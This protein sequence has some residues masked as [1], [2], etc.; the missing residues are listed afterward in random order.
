MSLDTLSC[1]K[2]ICCGWVSQVDNQL[3]E[4]QK[5][6]GISTNERTFTMNN[7]STLGSNVKRGIVRFCERISEG[8]RRPEF[9]FVAQMVY[10]I[11]GAQSCHLSKIARALNEKSSLKK[12][13]ERLARNLHSFSSRGT[14]LT[15]Y[16]KKIK[17]V[18]SERTILLFD[19]SDITKPCS[20]KMEYISP[21]YDGSTGE[22]G[23]GYST[24]GVTAL[25]AEKKLP[26]CV[27]T[28]VYSSIDPEF[29]S[30]DDEV[31]KAMDFVG[32]HFKKT[33]IRV[34][35]RG[36][37]AN[38]YY[39]RLIDQGEAFVIRAKR[40]RDVI[41]NGKRLNILALAKR[42]KGKYSLK[43]RKKNGMEAD[44]KISIVPVKLPCR[45]D[46][47]LNLVICNGFGQNP[48]MLLTSL[49]SDDNRL[50]VVITKVYLLRWRIE[51]FYGFKKQE[52]GFE[53]FRVRSLQSIQNLDLL[54][55]I[56][57]GWIGLISEKADDRS[58]VMEL[59]RL[60]RRI[61]GTPNFLFYAIADGFF[62]LAARLGKGIVDILCPKPP[63][64]QLSF[65]PVLGFRCSF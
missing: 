8:M 56:A 44:C 29:V 46:K 61:Y 26:I 24:L 10:G 17:G 7:H 5:N 58:M 43:F 11:L 32:Q 60:S 55:T 3:L 4:L 49:K 31:L 65:W 22:I 16:I 38:I 34:F 27:Y 2:S 48:L 21:V 45:A 33:S 52:L 64:P 25:T 53:G 13:I 62:F 28:R 9:K 50:S 63:S 14:L 35:D 37:D 30:E 41:H 1:P 39:E 54:V 18:L 57:V 36:Y 47:E 12:T 59:I 20:P 15:N 6:Q 19:G 23:Q 40:N 42:F 51:E